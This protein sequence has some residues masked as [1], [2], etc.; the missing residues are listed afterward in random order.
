MS[1][2]LGRKRCLGE[3]WRRNGAVAKKNEL[4]RGCF[5]LFRAFTNFFFKKISELK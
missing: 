5:E 1:G 3:K 4:F 2:S